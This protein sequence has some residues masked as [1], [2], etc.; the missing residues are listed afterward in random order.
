MKKSRVIYCSILLVLSFS[1]GIPKDGREAFQNALQN[2]LMVGV[3]EQAGEERSALD[4]EIEL[5]RQFGKEN[6]MKVELIYGPETKLVSRLENAEFQLVVGG[7][8]KETIWEEKVALSIPYDDFGHV[9]LIPKGE[10]RLL[11]ELENFIHLQ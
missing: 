2:R 10:N 7:F 3:V 11:F 6:N 8:D 9:F 5:V 4:A 1:C